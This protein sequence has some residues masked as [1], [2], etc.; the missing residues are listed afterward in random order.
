MTDEQKKNEQGLSKLFLQLRKSAPRDSKAKKQAKIN[1]L[2]QIEALGPAIAKPDSPKKSWLAG[3]PVLRAPAR[4]IASLVLAITILATSTGFVVASQSALPADPLYPLKIALEDLQLAFSIQDSDDARLLL[5]FSE[6]RLA[7]ADD[8]ISEERYDDLPISLDYYDEELLELANIIIQFVEADDPRADLLL[9]LL[10]QSLAENEILLSSLRADL[11]D[12]AGAAIGSAIEKAALAYE[13][14]DFDD[15]EIE[16]EV[17]F[18]GPLDG[19]TTENVQ[20][21]GL[22]FLLDDNAKIEGTLQIGEP[23]KIDFV[24]FGGAYIATK[25]EDENEGN[26]CELRLEGILDVRGDVE[27]INPWQVAGIDFLSHPSTQLLDDP[28]VGDFVHV[29][30]IVLEDGSFQALQIIA[31]PVEFEGHEE[32]DEE[33]ELVFD[34]QPAPTSK[35]ESEEEEREAQEIELTVESTETLAPTDEVNEQPESTE[36]STEEPESTEESSEEDDYEEIKFAG[37]VQSKSSGSW[38][39]NGKTV[40]ITSNSEVDSGINVGDEVDVRALKYPDG[41]I[42]AE[43]IE[44]VED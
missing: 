13:N 16:T 14:P 32:E 19:F 43:R 24:N 11:P 4:A 9:S 22:N 42:E 25:L 23:V 20:I 31:G 10:I 41:T 35:A 17:E 26:A 8:L 40:D 6:R 18:Y 15:L 28:Q 36:E 12:A 3:L 5:R 33:N 44:L 21:C 27:N 39:I 30:A 37:T 29:V 34:P 1:Y 38:T 2:A 7:E